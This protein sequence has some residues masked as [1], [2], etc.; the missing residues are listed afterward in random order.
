MLLKMLDVGTVRWLRSQRGGSYLCR[1]R[2]IY[3]GL[4]LFMWGQH[5]GV[6]YWFK[7]DGFSTENAGFV[8]VG[9]CL[10]IQLAMGGTRDIGEFVLLFYRKAMIL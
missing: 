1:I 7:H 6:L 3:G 10:G 2:P 8:G 5:D 9:T 4:D